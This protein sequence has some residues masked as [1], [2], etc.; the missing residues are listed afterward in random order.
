MFVGKMPAAKFHEDWTVFGTGLIQ[1]LLK[2]PVGGGLDR[3]ATAD[4]A[5][6][7]NTL[8][9]AE[10]GLLWLPIDSALPRGPTPSMCSPF[11]VVDL[12]TPFSQAKSMT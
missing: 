9:Q 11:L 8:S 6:H 4:G 1:S 3:S 10:Q 5:L 7:P 12:H 2:C